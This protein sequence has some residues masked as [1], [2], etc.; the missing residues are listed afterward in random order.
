MAGNTLKVNRRRT[1]TLFL[2]VL[3]SSFLVFTIFTV[4]DSY[5]RL[6]KIQNIRMSGA[7]FDAIMYGVTDEQKQMCED[8]PDIILTG[9]V[10][11][12]TDMEPKSSFLSQKNSMTAQAGVFPRQLPAVT[13]WIL[14]RNL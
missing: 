3:L 4:G 13:T 7:E 6:R 11:S 2:S 10:G 5:F 9:T 1:I 8:D 14:N 12:G